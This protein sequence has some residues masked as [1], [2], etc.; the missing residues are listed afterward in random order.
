MLNPGHKSMNFVAVSRS[1]LRCRVCLSVLRYE[2]D[3]WWYW[4]GYREGWVSWHRSRWYHRVDRRGFQGSLKHIVSD[5]QALGYSLR[6]G[7][8]LAHSRGSEEIFLWI[9]HLIFRHRYLAVIL[10]ILAI[11][12]HISTFLLTVRVGSERVLVLIWS[13]LSLLLPSLVAMV[14]LMPLA[15]P[16]RPEGS[17]PTG[18]LLQG[19]LRECEI[20]RL[21]VRCWHTIFKSVD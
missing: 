8:A 19:R 11:F 18:M 10:D 4:K 13:H 12:R 21:P 17:F 20:A 5:A 15:N 2:R 7:R 16:R 6:G 9:S 3:G 14:V 1:E